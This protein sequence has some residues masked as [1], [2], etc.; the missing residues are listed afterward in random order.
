MKGA[1]NMFDVIEMMHS[2]NIKSYEELCKIAV[3]ETVH[4][5]VRASISKVELITCIIASR[6]A[7]LSHTEDYVVKD[8]KAPDRKKYCLHCR[9]DDY[10]LELTKEQANFADWCIDHSIDFD[11]VNIDKMNDFKWETP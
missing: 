2:L 10:Y 9:E 11:F 6:V 7:A 3:K 4:I 5:P 8:N 1:L